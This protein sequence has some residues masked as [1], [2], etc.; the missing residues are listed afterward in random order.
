MRSLVAGLCLL[1]SVLVAAVAVGSE[2]PPERPDTKRVMFIGNNWAGTADVVDPETYQRLARIDLIPDKEERLREIQSDP[3]DYAFFLAIREQVGEGHDQFT[4]D[5]YTSADGRFVYVSR[6]SFADVAG[7]EIA[8]GKLAW[9][10]PME[11]QRSDHMAVSPDG[12]KLLVS[13]STANKAHQLDAATGKKTGEF[14]SGD[15]PHESVFSKDGKRIYHASIG[16]VYTPTDDPKLSIARDTTKGARYFQVVDAETMKV[17][18]RWDMGQKLEEAGF[19]D[20]ESAV[21]PMAITPDEKRVFL[22]VSFFH[23]LIEFDLASEK[24]VRVQD[25]PISE[26]ARALRPE[27]YLLDSAHHGLAIDP[28]GEKLCVA[29]TMSDYATIVDRETLKPGTPVPG[30]KPYWSTVGVDGNCW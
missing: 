28:T 4:D 11:G 6:P 12:T 29:G 10:F 14:P 17:V 5:M 1:A 2:G 15:S 3:K 18:K 19:P 20:L 30:E 9:R 16:R 27:Q 21:R 24:V 7:I 8:T 25:L 13:D 26:E 22:Q 23:G